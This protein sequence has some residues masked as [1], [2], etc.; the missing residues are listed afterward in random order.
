MLSEA[1]PPERPADPEIPFVGAERG[2]L[3]IKKSVDVAGLDGAGNPFRTFPELGAVALTVG[4]G[5]SVPSTVRSIF[6]KLV[7]TACKNAKLTAIKTQRT[8]RAVIVFMISVL[9][10]EI[11]VRCFPWPFPPIRT[12][13][14]K[15]CLDET[16]AVK[17]R[18]MA[19][20]GS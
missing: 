3:P 13:P 4:V 19:M 15:S 18:K 16:N 14:G 1:I 12:L 10:V 20:N 17:G 7:G 9:R 6:P 2:L 11:N 5:R 8:F